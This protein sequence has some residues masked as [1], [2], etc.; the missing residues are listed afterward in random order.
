LAAA[1]VRVLEHHHGD[2]RE[3]LTQCLQ[4]RKIRRYDMYQ[5]IRYSEHIQADF[6]VVT[7]G[8]EV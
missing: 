2:C 7:L 8:V 5:Y 1:T 4:T 3:T 6:D